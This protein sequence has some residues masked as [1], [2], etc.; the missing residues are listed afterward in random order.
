M[1]RRVLMVVTMM[2]AV[3][4][5][6]LVVPASGGKALAGPAI[7]KKK[8]ALDK[9][10]GFGNADGKDTVDGALWVFAATN[11]S[12]KQIRFRYRVTN[13][14]M[15][16]PDTDKQI[17]EV[18]NAGKGKSR[19]TMHKGTK[20]PATFGLEIDKAG[21]WLGNGKYDGDSWAIQVRCLDR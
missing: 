10:K 6:G 17:G 8:G 19:V 15:F 4:G 20:F 2:A 18:H 7:Q 11:R 9:K 16:D 21:L 3:V 1:R 13:S 5:A 14:I 12:G